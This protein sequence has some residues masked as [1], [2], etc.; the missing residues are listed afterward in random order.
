MPSE[1]DASLNTD[2]SDYDAAELLLQRMMPPEDKKDA[3]KPSKADGD[4]E[5]TKRTPAKEDD[6]D[7][8]SAEKPEDGA[9]ASDEEE[10]A[11]ADDQD[12][13][14]EDTSEEDDAEAVVKIKVKVEGEEHEVP[15]NELARLWGQEK[16]LTKKSMEVAEARK[17]Y[18]A[19][20]EEQL[21]ATKAILTRAE[22]RFKPYANLD[23]N[24]LA[25]QLPPEE[26]TALRQAAQAAYEDYVFLS[27]HT[28]DYAKKVQAEKA[29]TMRKAAADAIAVL[30]GPVEKGG[31][32]GWNEQLYNDI[33][34]FAIAQGA[35]AEEVNDIVAPW[36]IKMLHSAMLYAR[37]RT[38][39]A[40]KTVK[41]AHTPKKIVKTTTAPAS[42]SDK[43]DGGVK[44]HMD[45][46]KGSGSTDDAA[47][48]LLS[49][50]M[51]GRERD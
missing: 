12:G 46:L 40:V 20:L 17:E 32:E 14:D 27:Q 21:A 24:L 6:E 43:I 11:D 18:N 39:G 45:K 25:T 9:D 10:T 1:Q 50:M 2:L 29:Q 44:K 34:S 36:Q 51:S 49:R 41:V 38:K 33:R 48:V 35:P 19:K 5:E 13:S 28:G 3:D 30:S 47:E 26:Y 15:A 4:K 31:I 42:R 16:A 22:E 8:A 37:G 23:F 7:D